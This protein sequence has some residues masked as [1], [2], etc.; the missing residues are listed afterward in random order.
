M[1]ENN[2][3]VSKSKFDVRTLIGGIFVGVILVLLLMGVKIKPPTA[4]Q[5]QVNQ[6]QSFLSL[7]EEM[8]DMSQS[9]LLA[10]MET[11]EVKSAVI[12]DK[13]EAGMIGANVTPFSVMIDDK[14]RK[15]SFKGAKTKEEM[16]AMIDA[17]VSLSEK[18][19][20][21]AVVDSSAIPIREVDE[22]DYTRGSIN[23][24]VT[25]VEYFDF[26]CTFCRKFHETMV[27]IIEER[28][29]VS[30]VIRHLPFRKESEGL[31]SECIGQKFG[32]EA[33]WEYTDKLVSHFSQ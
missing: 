24:K 21:D 2:I 14:G 3:E 7:A 23:P 1:D 25:V 17:L 4:N 30:W 31:A 29:D 9:D 33:F 16:S 15:I 13:V 22:S 11:D 8:F 5:N 19:D 6:D 12:E 26:G 18:A 28:D 10:C 20:P 27:E 32:D